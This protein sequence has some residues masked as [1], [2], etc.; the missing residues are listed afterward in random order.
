MAN[1]NFKK[2]DIFYHFFLIF[3]QH[4]SFHGQLEKAD[5]GFSVVAD[6]F[7]RGLF[8]PQIDL[9]TLRVVEDQETSRPQTP[10]IST[11]IL[12]QGEPVIFSRRNFLKSTPLCD[13]LIRGW[14]SK[15]ASSHTCQNFCDSSQRCRRGIFIG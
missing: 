8:R 2:S 6:Y 4:D 11:S 5:D 13:F 3:P 1:Q 7:G 14:I 15:T 9:R 10:T 12:V